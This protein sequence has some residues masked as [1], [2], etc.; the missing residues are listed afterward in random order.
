MKLYH[1]V[2]AGYFRGLSAADQLLFLFVFAALLF[3]CVYCI[4]FLVVCQF[5]NAVAV[6]FFS[7]LF[8][9]A[10]FCGILFLDHIFLTEDKQNGNAA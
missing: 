8:T 3:P 4:I 7:A 6:Y 5:L 10:G 1:R 2:C 9:N